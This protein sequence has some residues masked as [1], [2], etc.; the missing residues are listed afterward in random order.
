M[1]ITR[2]NTLRADEWE[3]VEF[4][5]KRDLGRHGRYLEGLRTA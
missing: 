4:L 2:D 1:K 3:M 5:R